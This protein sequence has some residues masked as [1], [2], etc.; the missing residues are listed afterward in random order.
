MLVA[1][2]LLVLGVLGAGGFL[3][4]KWLAD[5]ASRQEALRVAEQGDFGNAEPLLTRIAQRH[6]GDA[7][8]ARALAL[9]YLSGNRLAEAEPYFERWCAARPGDPEPYHERIRLWLRW[10]R[11]RDVVAD[12]RRVLELDPDNRKLRQQLPRWLMIMGRF[13]EAEQECQRFLRLW[14]DDPWV[15][16]IQAFLHQRQGRPSAATAIVDRL[17]RDYADF[18]E[19]FVLRA[20]LYV[21]A[22]EPGQAIPWLQRAAAMPGPHRREALYELSLALARTGRSKDAER[23]MAEARLL[24]EQDHLGDMVRGSEAER[25]DRANVQV[26]LA[27]EMFKAGQSEDALRVVTRVL[28]QDPNFAPAQRLLAA[29][30]KK[31][32]QPKRAAGDRRPGPTP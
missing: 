10:S 27:E 21:E 18:P 15:L 5:R 17:V 14:P 7:A 16:L 24:Q 26:R 28:K 25:Q 30:P 22:D 13:E 6:P 32:E 11:L 19:A 1:A 31:Q 20:T 9:G 23:V 8:V 29:Y 12:A 4:W 2:L 3:T